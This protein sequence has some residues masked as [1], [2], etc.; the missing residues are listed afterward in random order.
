ME[1]REK[2]YITQK[3]RTPV[4]EECDVLVIGAGAAGLMAALSA[5]EQGVRTLLVEASPI[6]GGDMQAGGISWLSFYNNYSLSSEAKPVQLV[7]G[8]PYKVMKKFID[9]GA[10][11][12]FYE[13]PAPLTQESRG[14]HVDRDW[15]RIMFLKLIEEY[16]VKLYLNTTAVKAIKEEDVLKGV[17]FQ[18]NSCRFGIKAKVVIDTTGDGDVAFLAGANCYLYDNHRVG[19]AFGMN[20]VDFDQ[21]MEYA[22]KNREYLVHEAYGTQGERKGKL[23]K[24]ALRIRL[25]PELADKVEE[26]GIMGSHT[27][28]ISHEGEATYINGVN[29]HDSNALDS[30]KATDTIIRLRQNI[31]KSAQFLRENI[32]GFEKARVH[33]TSPVMG[34]RKTRYVECEYDITGD[35]VGQGVIPKD[36]IALFGSQDAHSAGFDIAEGGWYGIPYRALVPKFVDNLLVAG[37]MISSGWVPHMSTRLIVGCFAEGQAAGVAAALSV[38]SGTEPRKINIPELRK[39]LIDAGVYL[40]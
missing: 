2:K 22:H 34:P 18:T 20:N 40:G 21:V 1:I 6:P 29:T 19:M 13:D 12:G 38:K 3:I 7:Y 30:R 35:D 36:A 15:I 8:M 4:E 14:T 28:T 24:Y 17:I 26:C 32:P 5:A 27:M 31:F 39:T 37:R 11:P 25:M 9:I 23:V 33:W 16:G 10:S